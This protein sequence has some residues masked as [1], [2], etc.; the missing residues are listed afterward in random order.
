MTKV[1][2]RR[3]FLRGAGVALAVPWLDAMTPTFGA[4]AALPGP[5]RRMV[6]ACHSLSLHA[7]SFFPNKPGPDYEPSP[8]LEILKD[9]RRDLTVFSGLSH[10]GCLE[11]HEAERLFLTGCRGEPGGRITHLAR[12]AGGGKDRLANTAPLSCLS[13]RGLSRSRNGAKIPAMGSP[14]KIFARLFLDG[15]PRETEL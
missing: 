4:A 9:F 15:S 2:S 5:R 10:P 6:V 1:L 14:S 11:G 13:G 7:P 8:Y 3:T 12:P